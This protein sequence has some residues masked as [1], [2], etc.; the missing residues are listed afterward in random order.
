MVRDT[1]GDILLFRARDVTAPGLGEWWEL[2]GGGIDA[3]ETHVEAALREL[4]EEAG[5]AATP[6]QVGPA[7][8]RRLASFRYRF[9]RRL[10][11]E[12]VVAIGLAAR[13][14][15]IA[16]TGRLD[17]EIEDYPDFRW[18][19][20]AEIVGSRERFY[21]G[22]LPLLLPRF[23]AGEAIDEPFELWS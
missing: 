1:G 16:V 21:P 13:R 4:R 12:V 11:S 3:G 2:P 9:H 14:P 20:P 19:S 23:L 17:D 6:A 22:R 18:W 5:L 10:Q 8:W 7:S 15:E